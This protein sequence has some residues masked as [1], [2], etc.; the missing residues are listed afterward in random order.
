MQIQ[1]CQVGK[2]LPRSLLDAEP[3]GPFPHPHLLTQNCILT[4]LPGDQYVHLIFGIRSHRDFRSYLRF[5]IPFPPDS[6][7]LPPQ[8]VQ[9][10]TTKSALLLSLSSTPESHVSLITT[11]QCQFPT[12]IGKEME[13]LED[14]SASAG[15]GKGKNSSFQV[16]F[17]LK[18][19]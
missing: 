13:A 19:V 2:S 15:I 17:K 7:L 16:E 10:T 12:L 3:L 4:I 5:F 9:V 1:I 8:T 18:M 11:S 14:Q 6:P